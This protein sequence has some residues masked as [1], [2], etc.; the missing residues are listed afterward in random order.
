MNMKHI[1][2]GN[3]VFSFIFKNQLGIIFC[4]IFFFLSYCDLL[5][6][7]FFLKFFEMQTLNIFKLRNFL[8]VEDFSF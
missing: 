2:I 1:L 8:L 7:N 4:K 5:F 3:Y 6:E